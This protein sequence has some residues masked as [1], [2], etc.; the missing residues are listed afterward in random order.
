MS[1]SPPQTGDQAWQKPHVPGPSAEACIADA[2]RRIVSGFQPLQIL[3]F[4]SRARGT[5]RPD[6]DIDL[7]VVFPEVENH[8][9]K[10]AEILGV[11]E[12]LEYPKDVIVATPE[13]IK[14][15]SPW[16]GEVLY[17]AMAEAKVLYECSAENTIDVVAPDRVTCMRRWMQLAQ[18]DMT[19]A[20]K[21]LREGDHD[22]AAFRI[23]QAVEEALK[24]ALVAESVPLDR[25]HDLNRLLGKLP[26]PKG[27][28]LKGILD[29]E[30]VSSWAVATRY[31]NATGI[32]H[33]TPE[34]VRSTV[35]KAREFVGQVQKAFCDPQLSA[36]RRS[37]A[38]AEI[39]TDPA[40]Q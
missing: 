19:R 33:V 4:G 26:P 38:A 10:I 28:Q 18:E 2:V 39:P 24:A 7:I 30:Q 29:L 14:N 11:L 5:A 13:Q 6:S 12:D 15:R 21:R 31:P 32:H 20:G 1:K 37:N 8:L 27:N 9:E 16:T 25:T 22:A 36:R 3:L 40:P 17:G 35:G 23:Q 34:A